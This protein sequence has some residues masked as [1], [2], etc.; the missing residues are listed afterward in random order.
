MT[1]IVTLM[2]IVTL[3][4][5]V[6]EDMIC[7]GA[8]RIRCKFS[9]TWWILEYWSK[10]IL[11]ATKKSKW[12]EKSSKWWKA[13]AGQC[14]QVNALRSK[15]TYEITS[16]RNTTCFSPTNFHHHDTTDNVL[17]AFFGQTWMHKR[18]CPR[19]GFS[20]AVSLAAQKSIGV[21]SGILKGCIG[22][23]NLFAKL[24]V[25]YHRHLPVVSGAL[26]NW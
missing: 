4:G 5:T 2:D 24:F 17:L 15:Q 16:H 18:D 25:F 21:F 1:E 10:S 20:Q 14:H 9:Y 23:I 13:A 6:S 12:A 19:C 26:R 8:M 7:E 22:N 11:F 3:T